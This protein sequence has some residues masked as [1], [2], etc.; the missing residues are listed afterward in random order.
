[1]SL[2]QQI[3]DFMKENNLSQEKMGELIGFSQGTISK[4]VNG[5]KLSPNNDVIAKAFFNDFKDPDVSFIKLKLDCLEDIMANLKVGNTVY[6]DEH[7]F[8][9]KMED[10]IIYKYIEDDKLFSINPLI[11]LNEIY[12]IIDEAQLK[13]EVGKKYQ[14]QDGRVAIIFAKTASDRY[15]GVFEGD[16][17]VRSYP[18]NG[19]TNNGDNL[20][21]E[22]L[23]ANN[24]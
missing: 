6:N 13:L 18:E 22:Y 15:L 16:C 4:I 20:I 10:G 11:T 12:Y 21:K 23:E 19:I 17:S 9:L 5:A 8:Y 2:T 1:M 3:K 24:D 14:T 7:K